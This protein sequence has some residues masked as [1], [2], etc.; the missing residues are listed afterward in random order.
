M[1]LIFF[2]LLAGVL[3]SSYLLYTH[4]MFHIS[5]FCPIDACIPQEL[6]IPSYLLALLGLIWFLAGFF[7]IFVRSKPLAKFWQIL[8]VL[9][10]LG[11]FSYSATIGYNCYYC[12]LAHFLGIASVMAYE[13]EVRKCR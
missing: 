6:P 10:A 11:L 2:L 1:K 8:G 12:Y 7:I 3:D 13:R 4:Y 5:P 9:G